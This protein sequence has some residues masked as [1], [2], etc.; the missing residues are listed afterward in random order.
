M[1]CA[2]RWGAAK[3]DRAFSAQYSLPLSAL[4]AAC[5]AV[6]R[7]VPLEQRALVE[8]KFLAASD[9]TLVAPNSAA[10]S[11]ALVACLNVWCKAPP[12]PWAA[13]FEKAMQGQ[14]ATPHW[15]KSFDLPPGYLARLPTVTRFDNAVRTLG[16]DPLAASFDAHCE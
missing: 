13:A 9:A 8:V 5:C 10:G 11:D 16:G 1:N 4:A 6:A 15:G 7:A 2:R 3:D 14:N 12:P